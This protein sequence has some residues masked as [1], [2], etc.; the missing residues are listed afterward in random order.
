MDKRI[1]EAAEEWLLDDIN[2]IPLRV[3]DPTDNQM[4]VHVSGS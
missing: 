1:K 2:V 4:V 3:W